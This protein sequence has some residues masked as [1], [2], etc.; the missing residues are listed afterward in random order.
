MFGSI[1]KTRIDN[2]ARKLTN[3]IEISVKARQVRES[4]LANGMSMLKGAVAALGEHDAIGLPLDD[5]Q[6]RRL[7]STGREVWM[8]LRGT[9]G[10]DLDDYRKVRSR[11]A[12]GAY[13]DD[14]TI[15]DVVLA[16]VAGAF[17]AWLLTR[18]ESVHPSSVVRSMVPVSVES[19]SG[20][21]AAAHRRRAPA[22]ATAAASS[23]AKP[24]SPVMPRPR[25]SGATSDSPPS[26]A[27]PLS[28]PW[29]S[30]ACHTLPP[31]SRTQCKGGV[32]STQ[33]TTISSGPSTGI[34]G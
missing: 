1:E 26:V 6:T 32:S 20:S 16:T 11:L 29:N 5:P 28:V 4:A 14:V 25:Q 17:R 23:T 10:T 3:W 21:P 13:A 15:N 31:R 33:K 19:E 22:V 8:T 7:R 12:R 24:A 30:A 2:L 18:G 9:L 34:P 27:V